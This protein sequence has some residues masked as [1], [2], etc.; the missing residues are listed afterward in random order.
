VT[1]LILLTAH[2]L[3]FRKQ[4]ILGSEGRMPG[5]LSMLLLTAIGAVFI[6]LT[7]PV[8]ESTRGQL[9]G[10]LGLLLSAMI[11]L[12]STTLV[13]NAMAGLMLR[14][15]K[16]FRPGDFIR[17]DEQFGRVT[18]RGLFH[19]EIQTEDRDLTTL[20][21]LYLISHPVTVVHSTGTIV[22]TT[23]SLGYD[24]SHTSIEP[25]LIDAA[26]LAELQEPF[27]QVVNLGDFS[28][29]YRVAGFLPEVKQLLTARSTL[30]KAVL[31]TL[32]ANGVEIV[33]PGFMNQRQLPEG[34]AMI[35]DDTKTRPKKPVNSSQ[36]LPETLIFDKAD[37]AEELELTK[38]Q[39]QR[40]Q[41]EIKVL[42]SQLADAD[43]A[44][45]V[46]LEQQII[47][48]HAQSEKIEAILEDVKDS[49]IK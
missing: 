40:L 23:L 29:N 41:Q 2:W 27:V 36:T 6:I 25:L 9:L 38:E 24:I 8:E 13:A 33:S 45:K 30:R 4:N 49:K 1:G 43:E 32:H 5:Q 31:D 46:Q 22:S 17:V 14:T 35:P 19:T 34:S 39:H 20:P 42:E 21:N 47:L 3:L 7:L 26:R 16:S 37:Q 15:V 12:S 44:H 11:A 10:L 18:E 28:I 48:L